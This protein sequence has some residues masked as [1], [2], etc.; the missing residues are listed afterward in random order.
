M[1]KDATRK[2]LGFCASDHAS[3][4]DFQ[5]S[6][7]LLVTGEKNVQFLTDVIAKYCNNESFHYKD[8]GD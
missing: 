5:F 4:K 7:F 8:I 6:I 2:V 1:W 3:A